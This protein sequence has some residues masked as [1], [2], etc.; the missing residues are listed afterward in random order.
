MRMGLRH[1]FWLAL[2]GVVLGLL[3]V[4]GAWAALLW[5]QLGPAER[6]AVAAVLGRRPLF[7]L[8][9]VAML[10]VA[11]HALLRHW[12]ARYPRAARRLAEET[13]I[14][15]TANPAHR[16][17]AEGAE[18]IAR[19]G[20]RINALAEQHQG[21]LR[22][23]EA[24][25][26]AA[27]AELA[28]E[29]NRLAALISE[30]VQGVVVTN[31]EGRI[32]LYNQRA[33][34]ILQPDDDGGDGDAGG[35]VGLGRSLYSLLD[36]AAVGHAVE[37]LQQ[38]RERG[39]EGPVARF[40][41]YTRAGLLLRVHLALV[42]GEGEGGIAGYVLTVEDVT[43]S[44]EADR[45]RGTLLR[46]LTEGI[47]SPVAAI[48]AASE[49]LE[50]FPGM[51]PEQR[52]RF[53]AIVRD[54]TL[55]LSGRLEETLSRYA[56]HLE[57]EWPL[58]EMSAGDLLAVLERGFATWASVAT[59]ARHASD[60]LWVRVDSYALMLG[61]TRLVRR[62][63]EN[64]AVEEVTLDV[65]RAE[66]FAR[67][68]LIWSGR[69]LDAGTLRAWQEEPLADHGYGSL[70]TL[71]EVIKRHGGAAWSQCD[72]TTGRAFFRL[73]LPR[74]DG[75]PDGALHLPRGSRPEFY[76]FDLFAGP[77]AGTELDRVPLAELVF[78]VFDTETTGLNPSQGDEIVA[79]GAV[80]IVNGRLLRYEIFDQ[81]IN[82]RRRISL[83]SQAVH[84]ISNEMLAEE[85][86]LEVVLPRFHRFA[87]DAVLVAHNAAFDMRFLQL[88]E[89]RS[90]I[91]FAHPVLD[92]LL[93]S[94]VAQPEEED[95]GL[96]AIAARLGIPVIG[97]HTSL[98][99]A[100]LTAQVFLKLLPLLAAEGITTLGEARDAS[101]RTLLARLRY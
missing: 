34:Q 82:P 80:R 26:D 5:V 72:R 77:A 100:L 37:T 56:E 96:D 68:D 20:G 67:L 64:E 3:G 39:D 48:R 63:R 8:V 13:R 76:D 53:E 2:A 87:E 84:G 6:E 83:E 88:A 21:V 11:C 55:T 89:R 94:A 42:L 73:F 44:I 71:A 9:L 28:E 85:P 74:A 75:G 97:R 35:I 25:V 69:A 14:V 95:H 93:L 17:T 61:L 31:V 16:V 58:E 50:A 23:V 36:A 40:V 12:F 86:P 24:R 81:R 30:L 62:L 10:A 52:R 90:R 66:P 54:E 101:Q 45:G 27:R 7:P 15:L 18:E 98:G 29:R 4:I 65:E 49:T 70:L 38:R 33:R 91:R 47:R 99:D 41:T 57:A 78:T 79:I 59:R 19:I 22:E 51:E 32:L 43:R 46:A 60:A 92:T 1:R